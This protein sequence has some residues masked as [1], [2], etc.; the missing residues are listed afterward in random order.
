M[1]DVESLA[2]TKRSSWI[3]KCID[4][5][6][7]V[8]V[9]N[10]TSFDELKKLIPP[11]RLSKV[12][13]IPHGN[14][15]HEGLPVSRDE[16]LS[17][18]GLDGDKFYLLFFGMIKKS[19]GLEVLIESLAKLP[20]EVHLIIAGRTRDIDFSFYRRKIL[21]MQL[22]GRVHEYIRYITN[23]ERKMLF[24]I[25]DAAVLPYHRIYQSG[26]A[27]YSMSNGTPVIAS[28]LPAFREL[29]K[30][31][32]NGLLFQPGSPDDL[33]K[34]VQVLLYKKE[35]K[36]SIALEAKKFVKDHHNWN[37]SSKLLLIALD[38]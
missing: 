7:H 11:E 30:E 20:E 35:L 24:A 27:L 16:G 36:G 2:F 29:V 19:K 1:H 18:F 38:R 34:N 12:T 8:I 17:S 13:V 5:S 6:Q 37:E 33:E 28:G 15:L 23:E 32:V 31:G 22:S 26:V 10:Q 3:L 25:A 9:H 4:K 14:Y 21:K